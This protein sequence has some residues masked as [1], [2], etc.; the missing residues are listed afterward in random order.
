MDD[1]D[2][3]DEHWSSLGTQE[4]T[5]RIQS[6]HR[7]YSVRKSAAARAARAALE[8]FEHLKP[9]TPIKLIRFFAT[10]P[11]HFSTLVHRAKLTRYLKPKSALH[12]LSCLRR[13]SCPLD[14]AQFIHIS[15]Q[16]NNEKIVNRTAI[17]AFYIY[18]GSKPSLA[19]L[20]RAFATNPDTTAAYARNAGMQHLLVPKTAAAAFQNIRR[21][22]SRNRNKVSCS[23][24]IIE[25]MSSM[26][27]RAQQATSI[28]SPWCVT[29]QE[30]IKHVASYRRKDYAAEVYTDLALYTSE[31][32]KNVTLVSLHRALSHDATPSDHLSITT[33]IR[34]AHMSCL[35]S[36]KSA[37][38]AFS[39]LRALQD[40]EDF[41]SPVTLKNFRTLAKLNF[42]NSPPPPPS[43]PL[44]DLCLMMQCPP[45]SLSFGRWLRL[46]FSVGNMDKLRDQITLS[47]L[48]PLL[49]PRHAKSA[50]RDMNCVANIQHLSGIDKFKHYVEFG[51]SWTKSAT[52]LQSFSR[53]RVKEHRTRKIACC[54]I[55]K[56]YRW[57]WG[58]LPW[59]VA[60]V[61]IQ[62]QWKIVL[63]HAHESDMKEIIAMMIEHGLKE[64]RRAL[65]EMCRER[66][67]F[68]LNVL[69][70]TRQLYILDVI[71]DQR[72]DVLKHSRSS[73]IARWWKNIRTAY[74]CDRWVK[75]FRNYREL[76]AVV[77]QSVARGH[78]VRAER[79]RTLN[80]AAVVIQDGWKSRNIYPEEAVAAAQQ[81]KQAILSIQ[82]CWRGSLLRHDMN[83][84]FVWYWVAPLLQ[85]LARG[86]LLR[87]VHPLGRYFRTHL[88]M[89]MK[90]WKRCSEMK[91]ECHLLAK[92]RKE[93]ALTLSK[94]KKHGMRKYKALERVEDQLVNLKD[95]P[96]QHLI[97]VGRQLKFAADA[98][99]RRLQK[100]YPQ[101]R[102]ASTR[103]SSTSPVRRKKQRVKFLSPVRSR[104]GGVAYTA[105]DEAQALLHLE[106][107]QEEAN[108]LL[109]QLQRQMNVL[110]AKFESDNR[111]IKA[112]CKE[113]VAKAH[114][115]VADRQLR[116]E[117]AVS[118][119]KQVY[120]THEKIVQS[121][122]DSDKAFGLTFKIKTDSLTEAGRSMSTK[123]ETLPAV[124][125]NAVTCASNWNS[126]G[127]LLE[128]SND[129]K[130]LFT[131]KI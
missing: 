23:T 39:H 73:R 61:R 59:A 67:Y 122:V 72:I 2:D 94:T 29:L 87:H 80:S 34:K 129:P 131:V 85:A 124:D 38:K 79:R 83:R 102:V 30:L 118:N 125:Q 127:L 28:R 100:L 56:C 49:V 48:S 9:F 65:E 24:T 33:K 43:D 69:F 117:L 112:E 55:Q 53:I 51:L 106:T 119:L 46:Q 31:K 7:G 113:K 35:L 120:E 82:S 121:G 95:N 26:E 116:H 41:G 101:Y 50:F 104:R 128:N 52:T 86:Y 11:D 75:K 58:L 32:N 108:L 14:L 76:G 36:P 89:Y 96:Q 130:G 4:S 123:V 114:R 19:S 47:G 17:E 18:L 13:Y 42:P 78:L 74:I 103:S 62:R 92:Q 5:I 25:P 111:K 115:S 109:N 1:I 12:T 70:S 45:N 60:S 3:I 15:L 99:R 97:Q 20:T 88:P 57:R 54:T 98:E 63:R 6:L 10:N 126:A 68:V 27:E 16:L 91:Q 37:T 81:R 44:T 64:R 77:L 90:S 110:Q 93:K 8:L 71:R 21:N 105:H 84:T 107:E 40:H 22:R 66:I